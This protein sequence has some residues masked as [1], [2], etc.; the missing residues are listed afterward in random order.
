MDKLRIVV[1][2]LLVPK[3]SDKQIL[4]EALA[5]GWSDDPGQ[6][7][8]ILMKD[9]RGN[10]AYEV[11]NPMPHALP[12]GFEPTPPLDQLIRDRVRAEFQRLKDDEV[13]DSVEEADDFDIPDEIPL[14]SVYEVV[15]MDPEAP[16]LRPNLE[17]QAKQYVDTIE[18]VEREKYARKRAREQ[19]IQSQREALGTLEQEASL[20]ADSAF[21]ER[22]DGKIDGAKQ[23]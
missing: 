13:I 20:Y 11:H 6:G 5:A 1:D 12:I 8:A 7:K 16:A 3:A 9:A 19:A 22:L 10:G 23:S 4:D 18:L 17:E 2:P 21:Q 15:E 14:T